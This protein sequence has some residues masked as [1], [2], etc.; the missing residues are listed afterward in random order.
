MN[1]LDGQDRRQGGDNGPFLTDFLV[2]KVPGKSA[3]SVAKQITGLTE[4]TVKL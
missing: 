1:Q 2:G 4:P 3:H